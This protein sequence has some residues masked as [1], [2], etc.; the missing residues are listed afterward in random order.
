MG[1]ITSLFQYGSPPESFLKDELTFLHPLED[2]L[3]IECPICLQV[4]LHDPYIV[5]CC[6]HHFCYY[7]IT[8]TKR[9][10][11]SCP[12]CKS[13]SYDMI[14]DK[15]LDRI[16]K[17][18]PVKCT[19]HRSGCKWNGILQT[20]SDHLSKQN[21]EGECL[22]VA[23]ACK[24][25][26][27]Y[28]DA[29]CKL[30]FHEETAC[31]KRPYVC[32]Y[33]EHKSTYEDITGVHINTCDMFPVQ[34]PNICNRSL[35]LQRRMVKG[36]LKDECPLEIVSCIYKDEGCKWKGQ[37]KEL[38]LH[39]ENNMTEH[40]HLVSKVTQSLR[41]ENTSIKIELNELKSL[42]KKAASELRRQSSELDKLKNELKEY[43]VQQRNERIVYYRN[44]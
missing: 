23:V 9:R 13:T 7:C 37:R 44:R 25:G 36:H 17:S 12:Y 19:E 4:M 33:C 26:C 31:P 24:S 18:L 1:Q 42:T 3:E 6:G 40:L 30:A 43:K 35:V 34:C 11:S 5:S 39:C 2:H 38:S 21:R 32:M 15:G 27:N 16:I 41:E 14:P 20:L 29:R 28:R 10:D 8:Q 22:Y